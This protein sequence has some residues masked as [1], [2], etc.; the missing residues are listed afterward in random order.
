VLAFGIVGHLFLNVVYEEQGNTTVNY[1]GPSSSEALFP[2]G[3]NAHQMKVK[4]DIP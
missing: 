1:N 2:Q 3:H 4:K